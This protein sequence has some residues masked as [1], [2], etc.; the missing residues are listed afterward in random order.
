[1]CLAGKA[2]GPRPTPPRFPANGRKKHKN[3]QKAEENLSG[4]FSRM[5]TEVLIFVSFCDFYGRFLLV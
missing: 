4:G 1:M 2:N 5:T 3:A